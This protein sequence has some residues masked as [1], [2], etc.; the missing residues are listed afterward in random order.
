MTDAEVDARLRYMAAQSHQREDRLHERME[1]DGTLDNLR[2]QIRDDKVLRLLLEK[3]QITIPAPVE[4]KV[5]EKPAAKAEEKPE[6]KAE[7]KP[8]AKAEEKPAAKAEEKSEAEKAP[9]PKAEEKP[10]AEKAPKP[11]AEK[12]PK[13]KGVKKPAAPKTPEASGD[14]QST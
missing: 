14:V 7:E 1:A 9:K 8:E 3:A 5:E 10:E 4:P 12:K 6:P 13:A 11:K 2:S